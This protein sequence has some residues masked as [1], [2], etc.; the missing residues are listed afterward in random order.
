MSSIFLNF[1]EKIVK[2]FWL[3][4]PKGIL[5]FRAGIE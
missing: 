1:F 2:K 5:P 4:R 3:F